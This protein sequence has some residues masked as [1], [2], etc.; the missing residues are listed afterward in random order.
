[1]LYVPSTNASTE[2]DPLKASAGKAGVGKA[3]LGAIF[4]NVITNQPPIKSNHYRNQRNVQPRTNP[5]TN[6]RPESRHK[7]AVRNYQPTNEQPQP[8]RTPGYG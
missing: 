3:R 4:T 7:A 2:P 6:E 1:M 5:V 8:K